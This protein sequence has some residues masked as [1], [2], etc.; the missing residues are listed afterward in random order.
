[1]VIKPSVT[2][3]ISGVIF[4]I[5]VHD[6]CSMKITLPK[7]DQLR[8]RFDDEGIGFF[9]KETTIVKK[10]AGRTCDAVFIHV[11]SKVYLSSYV[12]ALLL[13]GR[14]VEKTKKIAKV[15]EAGLLKVFFDDFHA[16]SKELADREERLRNNDDLTLST[17]RTY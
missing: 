5:A 2:A 7:A 10:L 15:V 16:V 14:S 8:Q 11:M 17:K 6:I 1:M 9:A 13:K 12:Y 3:L 4:L